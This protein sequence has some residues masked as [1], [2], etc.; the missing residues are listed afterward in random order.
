MWV[1]ETSSTA[2]VAPVVMLLCVLPLPVLARMGSVGV[3]WQAARSA[4]VASKVKTPAVSSFNRMFD[5]WRPAA[6]PAH[7]FPGSQ[8]VAKGRRDDQRRI[9]GLANLGAADGK[10][11]VAPQPPGLRLQVDHETRVEQNEGS[12]AQVG[13]CAPVAQRQAARRIVRLAIDGGVIN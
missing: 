6:V 5:Q 13:Q 9:A 11:R 4:A 8:D 12:Q 10:L 1:A 3:P 7:F 2:A